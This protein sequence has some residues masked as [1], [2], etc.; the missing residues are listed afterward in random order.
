MTKQQ[1][2]EAR[3][4]V[5]TFDGHTARV[6]VNSA[7]EWYI[8]RDV[9]CGQ[10]TL[11]LNRDGK[12]ESAAVDRWPTMEAAIGFARFGPVKV[13][14]TEPKRLNLDQLVVERTAA[15]I[16]KADL[17]DFYHKHWDALIVE[18]REARRAASWANY[19]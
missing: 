2:L 16:D 17:F 8:H 14:T 10:S 9:R 12:W 6:D 19:D 5:P 11:Y 18:L 1:E 7:E 3:M 4:N 13:E 15:E